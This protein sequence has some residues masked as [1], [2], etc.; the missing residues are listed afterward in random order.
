MATNTWE[1]DCGNVEYGEF[2][3]EE[4]QE[5]WKNNSFLEV[6]EDRMEEVNGDRLLSEIKPEED[7]D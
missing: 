4:C 1:C 3:P 7:E 2:P 6:S 5:C